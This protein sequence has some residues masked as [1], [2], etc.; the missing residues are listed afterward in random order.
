MNHKTNLVAIEGVTDEDANQVTLLVAGVTQ[1]EPVN[2]LGDGDASPDAMTQSGN[3]PNTV[4]L[5]AERAGGGN[6]RVYE[7]TFTA[8]DGIEIC[9][10]SV[11]VGVPHDK[12][13]TA[14]DDGQFYDSTQP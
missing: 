11:K 1:D 4:R 5:R 3:A 13:N 14:I 9:T 7:V 8:D 6:G 10:G 12:K 2:G